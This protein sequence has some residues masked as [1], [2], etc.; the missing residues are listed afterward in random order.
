MTA[1]DQSPPSRQALGTAQLSGAGEQEF[2]SFA[3]AVTHVRQKGASDASELD[4][5]PALTKYYVC[6]VP[7]CG[8][9]FLTGLLKATGAFG[10]PAEW[11][12]PSWAEKQLELTGA[13]TWPAFVERVLAAHQSENRVS[14]LEIAHAHLT[15][16]RR[17]EGK[18][19]RLPRDGVF[20]Y[21]RRRNIVR[22]AISL[23]IAHQSGV[24]H[25]DQLT[26]DA[27]TV[28]DAVMYDTRAIRNFIKLLQ[29][30]EMRWER[31]FGSMAIEPVRLYYEDLVQRPERILRL[32]AQVLGLPETPR[33]PDDNPVRK[34]S[35]DRTAEWEARY[36]EEEADFLSGVQRLRP[37]MHRLVQEV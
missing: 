17:S 16:A 4:A 29:D 15:W 20:F 7:R 34:M 37:F 31:E 30:E 14:G 36:R 9:T 33:L 32:F 28:R 10:D 1:S 2:A 35:N 6:L 13:Q 3:D 27:Q 25:S 21:L 18:S 26:E 22:Q 8:S 11:V 24:W 23:H 12:G 5:R 19:L